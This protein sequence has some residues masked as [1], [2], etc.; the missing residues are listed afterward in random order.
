MK[1]SIIAAVDDHLGIGKNN[2]L[3]WHLKADF[4]NFVAVT[5][6]SGNNAVIMGSNTWRSLP[7]KFRPLKDRLNVVLNQDVNL[8]LPAGVLLFTSLDQALASL[9]T[10]NLTEVFVI[11]GA[12]LY[13]TAIEH[14]DCVKLYLTRI[15]ATFDCDV[16]FPALPDRFKLVSETE[17]QSEGDLKFK[18]LVYQTNPS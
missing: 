14:P 4:K 1:F 5:V 10:K 9:A 3:P 16:Y 6:G 17:V 2:D 7:R 12:R 8:E 15:L 18:F 13:A 11:G